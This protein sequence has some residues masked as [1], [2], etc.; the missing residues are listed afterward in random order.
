[1]KNEYLICERKEFKIQNF[2]KGK[3]ED[4]CIEITN[5]FGDR[6]V[7]SVIY[8][9]PQVNI[10]LFIKQ[11]E[12]SLSKIENDKTIKH[13]ILTGDF[14]IDF[15]KSDVNNNTNEYLNTLIENGFIPTILLPARVTSHAR[16]LIDHIFY[17]SRNSRIQVIS[18]NLMTD[19]NNHF[20]N[21]LILHSCAK[22]KAAHRPK[23]RI[24]SDRNKNYFKRLIG[25]IK[26]ETELISKNT[27]EVMLA[28][29]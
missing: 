2:S 5:T 14:K 27:N 1:M 15:I 12:S 28:F 26:E 4:L 10:K 23:V 18:G 11:L 9:H 24:F 13:S 22:S 19:M 29:N 25:E 20:A 6:Y 8:R 3:V 21:F 17:L 16:T 7:V